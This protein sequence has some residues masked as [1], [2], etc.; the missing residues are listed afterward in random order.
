MRR[1]GGLVV[2]HLLNNQKIVGSNPTK[3]YTVGSN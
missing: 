3:I 1:H 2:G